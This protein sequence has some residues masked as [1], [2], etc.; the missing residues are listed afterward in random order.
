MGREVVVD[1]VKAER[2]DV[3]LQGGY[4]VGDVEL[5]Q[6]RGVDDAKLANFYALYH[7]I[8]MSSREEGGAVRL[9]PAVASLE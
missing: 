9:Q 2:L 4:G 5:L 7:D 8:C 6:H 1:L 3:E